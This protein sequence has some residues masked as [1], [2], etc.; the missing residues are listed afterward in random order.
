MG[1][2]PARKGPTLSLSKTQNVT[3]LTSQISSSWRMLSW[4]SLA[5]RVMV[6]NDGVGV[7][8]D[9]PLASDN[10]NPATPRTGTALLRRFR[11]EVRDTKILRRLTARLILKPPQD[12]PNELSAHTP[13]R[14]KD[15]KSGCYKHVFL[16]GGF[17]CRRRRAPGKI[18]GLRRAA[19]R[20]WPKC[21]LHARSRIHAREPGF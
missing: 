14:G 8:M 17:H 10:D 4:L 6:S 9:A 21:R 16:P 1:R 13:P 12:T 2:S 18:S 19:Q 7:A 20:L 15:K 11:L 3:K 5:L